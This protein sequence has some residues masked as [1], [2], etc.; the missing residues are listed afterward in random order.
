MQWHLLKTLGRVAPRAAFSRSCVVCPSVREEAPSLSSHRTRPSFATH[1]DSFKKGREYALQR[2]ENEDQFECFTNPI[3]CRLPTVCP[4]SWR[5]FK[6]ASSSL[7]VAFCSPSLSTQG[8][9]SGQ[10]RER[11]KER[12]KAFCVARFT[13]LCTIL[14]EGRTPDLGVQYRGY[15][16]VL[17]MTFLGSNQMD[18][19]CTKSHI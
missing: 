8:R 15:K 16:M 6:W 18:I 14:S 7:P 12:K 9:L 10:R 13:A 1:P 3:P 17:H 11:K 2:R 4:T 19:L 5:S